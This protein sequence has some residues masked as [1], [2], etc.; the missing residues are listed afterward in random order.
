MSTYLK[1]FMFHS[2]EAERKLLKLEKRS[3]FDDTYPFGL[4][5]LRRLEKV[6]FEPVTIFY[7]GNGSG[8]TTILNIIANKIKA[9]R[10]LP[11]VPTQFF[12][13][14]VNG[15]SGYDP[16][17]GRIELPG[18]QYNQSLPE[19]MRSVPEGTRILCGE[20]VVDHVLRVRKRNHEINR[21]RVALAN[22]WYEARYVGSAERLFTINGPEGDDWF[23][24]MKLRK[25]SQSQLISRELGHNVKTGSN[26]ENAFGYFLEKITGNSLYLLDEPE[27]SLAGSW[28]RRLAE[29]I[30]ASARFENAQFIIATH[31]P[32]ILGIKGAKI[33]DLDS[34]TVQVRKWTEL[35]NVREYFDFFNAHRSEF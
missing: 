33:Y 27:N 14:Y 13:W 25:M 29:Y 32:F 6:E 10:E 18:V 12:D 3:C 11:F 16:M 4:F 30:E 19:K 9:L 7:G 2:D 34:S 15:A 20:D 24:E 28:Q 8:K 23:R 17:V 5:P 31:S 22:E 1:D 26:G 21:K 35:D